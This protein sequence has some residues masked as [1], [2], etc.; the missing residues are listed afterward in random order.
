VRP[1][2]FFLTTKPPQQARHESSTV[3]FFFSFY[4]AGAKQNTSIFLPFFFSIIISPIL[5]YIPYLQKCINQSLCT[6]QLFSP[7]MAL[8]LDTLLAKCTRL[9]QNGRKH[10]IDRRRWV[11]RLPRSSQRRIASIS[12]IG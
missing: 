9:S 2:S 3:I 10:N 11:L 4:S 6:Q 1:G 5:K 8:L 7:L 12:A